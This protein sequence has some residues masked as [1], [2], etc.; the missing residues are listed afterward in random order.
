[1]STN[2]QPY[3]VNRF[4]RGEAEVLCPEPVSL[5]CISTS[6]FLGFVL[7]CACLCVCTLGPKP[8]IR[9]EHPSLDR[10]DSDGYEKVH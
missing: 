10:W 1:M 3:T 4:T 7:S 5:V 6:L 2:V 8:V 9:V